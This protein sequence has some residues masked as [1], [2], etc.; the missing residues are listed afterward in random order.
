MDEI[1]ELGTISSRGQVCI[2]NNIREELG[3]TDGSKILFCLQDSA[4]VI[5]KVDSATFAQ[6]TKPLKEL[7]KKAKLDESQVNTIVHK[8]RTGL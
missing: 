3:L 4:L 6:I 5:K 1:I 2:P 7:A 8:A